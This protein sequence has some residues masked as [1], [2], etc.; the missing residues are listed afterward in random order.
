[1]RWGESYDGKN[2]KR[3]VFILSLLLMMVP[4][5]TLAQDDLNV[6]VHPEDEKLNFYGLA[7][8]N[9]TFI[10]YLQLTA[11]G[12][13]VERFR[14]TTHELKR[15]DA[16]GGEIP[17]T[18]V[19]FTGDKTLRDGIP[20]VFPV[21]IITLVE[22]PGIYEGT[23]EIVPIGQTQFETK[24]I[25]LR[26]EAEARPSL[27][28]VAQVGYI[29]FL[30]VAIFLLAI[31]VIRAGVGRRSMPKDE[32][33]WLDYGNFYVVTWGIVAVIIGL[34]AILL[35]IDRFEDVT[36]ALGFLSAFFGAVVGLVGTFFGI[37]ASADATVGAQELAA[38]KGGDTTPPQVHSTN[39]QDK[40]GDVPPDIHPT[41]TFSKDIDPATINSNTFKLLDQVTGQQVE[42][43]PLSG[44][45]YDEPTKVATFIPANALENDRRY[46]ATIT[47]GVRDKSGNVLAQDHTWHFT[48]RS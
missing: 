27:L 23:A 26:L 8:E 44:V 5:P 38:A 42:P 16:D 15:V 47:S 29:L 20:K 3:W 33:S 36:Q 14:F 1:M 34:L 12:G 35:F 31:L 9:E 24:E 37:K 18:R 25:E 46:G 30:L 6:D 21:T 41:A 28:S 43:L 22:E 45:V 7:G 40:A 19:R 2:V 13:D 10:D 39:P 11:T 17:R 32:R 48:T 4:M